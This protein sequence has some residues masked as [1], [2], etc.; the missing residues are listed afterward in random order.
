MQKEHEQKISAIWED[1]DLEATRHLDFPLVQA[2][3]RSLNISIGDSEL[4]RVFNWIDKEERGAINCDEFVNWM[5]DGVETSD[6]RDLQHK[7][8][9]FLD[10]TVKGSAEMSQQLKDNEKKKLQAIYRKNYDKDMSNVQSFEL[11]N[12]FDP[13][14]SL[15]KDS[16]KNGDQYWRKKQSNDNNNNNQGAS[17]PSKPPLKYNQGQHNNGS[18]DPDDHSGNNNNN[19]NNDNDESYDFNNI[20][21]LKVAKTVLFRNGKFVSIPVNEINDILDKNNNQKMRI[22]VVIINKIV[23]Y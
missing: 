17:H 23:I 6:Q 11:T 4:H 18:L 7:I 10:K 14:P 5:R 20:E 1:V 19:N 16:Y 21:E 15:P 2:V 3:F 12:Q 9:N 13:A 22:M 8:F